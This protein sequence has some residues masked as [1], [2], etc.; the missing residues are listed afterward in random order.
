[1]GGGFL[2]LSNSRSLNFRPPKA[3]LAFEAWLITPQPVAG[4]S[5]T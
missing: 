3:R 4:V 2:G 1:M 5:L